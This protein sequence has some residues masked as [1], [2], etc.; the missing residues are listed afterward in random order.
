MIW[1]G[2]PGTL[3]HTVLNRVL[4]VC[5]GA[6]LWH[7]GFNFSISALAA[8]GGTSIIITLSSLDWLCALAGQAL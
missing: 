5:E 3:A 7:A 1:K 2:V 6:L 4:T 8:A